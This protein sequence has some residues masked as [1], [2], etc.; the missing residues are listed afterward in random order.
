MGKIT[1]FRDF[2]D[3]DQIVEKMW[4]QDQDQILQTM[5]WS[6]RFRRALSWRSTSKITLLL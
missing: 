1:N 6:W 2:E 5:W 3:Q 4:F